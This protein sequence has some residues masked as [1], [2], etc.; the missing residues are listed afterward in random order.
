MA[1]YIRL[2]IRAPHGLLESQAA[3]GAPSPVPAMVLSLRLWPILDAFTRRE[4]QGPHGLL[5]KNQATTNLRQ[6]EYATQQCEH[7]LTLGKNHY[8]LNLFLNSVVLN[9]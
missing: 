8:A 6:G 4:I 3:I 7:L 1:N 9:C 2:L 5:A